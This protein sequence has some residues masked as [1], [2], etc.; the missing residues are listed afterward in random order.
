MPFPGAA[1]PGASPP[2]APAPRPRGPRTWLLSAAAAILTGGGAVSRGLGLRFSRIRDAGHLFVPRGPPG[3]HLW[4]NVCS[5]PLP[6]FDPTICCFCAKCRRSLSSLD[7]SPP[8]PHGLQR[9]LPVCRLPAALAG[10][11]LSV[12]VPPCVCF[13]CR[14][15]RPDG[16]LRVASHV[17]GSHVHGKQQWPSCGIP[18]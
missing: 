4:R 14:R 7:I 10:P 9:S 8:Q 13:C 3:R 15:A 11:R 16:L 2:A 18:L 1:A 6:V 12:P 17:L 5:S